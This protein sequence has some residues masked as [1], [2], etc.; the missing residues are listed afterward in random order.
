MG[1]TFGRLDGVARKYAPKVQPRRMA[2]AVLSGLLNPGKSGSLF[3]DPTKIFEAGDCLANMGL[4]E[5]TALALVP[6]TDESG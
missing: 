4:G 3:P 5:Q 2:W 6:L 1:A